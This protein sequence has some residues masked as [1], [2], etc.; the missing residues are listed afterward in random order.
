MKN[1]DVVIVG[2]GPAGVT[3]AISAKNTYPDKKVVLIRKESKPLIPCGIPYTLNTLNN[4]DDDILPDNPLIVNNIEIINAEVTGYVNKNLL[5]SNG[6]EVHY[7]KLVIAT[8]SVAVMPPIQGA[9]KSGVL[10]VEK[11]R[12]YLENLKSKIAASE[13]IIILGGG[14]IGVEVA[15]ELLDLQ[16]DIT[17]VEM[18]D[19]LIP[20]MDDEFGK[21][22]ET[23]LLERG[24]KV[25]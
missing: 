14:Y 11:R 5:L 3:C 23:I 24:C 8:G 16:K 25:I 10:L 6:N 7:E 20:T 21:N 12:D 19:T 2:G 4:I 1:Y 13:K 17:I 18:K 9:E 22:V 15:D